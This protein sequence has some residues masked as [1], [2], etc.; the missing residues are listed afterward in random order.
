MT[1]IPFPGPSTEVKSGSLRSSRRTH[2][3]LQTALPGPRPSSSGLERPAVLA[4]TPRFARAPSP[5]AGVE[6][7]LG[8]GGGIPGERRQRTPG[9]PL[10]KFISLFN[11]SLIHSF[12]FPRIFDKMGKCCPCI[13]WRGRPIYQH[14]LWAH[15]L[16]RPLARSLYSEP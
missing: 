9:E 14:T 8:W 10:E 12:S 11:L 2:Q 3:G 5:G 4:R 16:C 6:A 15:S 1:E 13:S 7:E